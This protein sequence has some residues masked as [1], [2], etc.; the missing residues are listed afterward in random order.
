MQN[1]GEL[2]GWVNSPES[3]L[4]PAPNHAFA[5][6]KNKERNGITRDQFFYDR[7]GNRLK[8]IRHVITKYIYDPWGN[9]L[10]ETNEFN[11]QLFFLCLLHGRSQFPPN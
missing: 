11:Q 5:E 6:C 2:S 4:L 3:F 8:A 1:L 7:G 9:L 10:A